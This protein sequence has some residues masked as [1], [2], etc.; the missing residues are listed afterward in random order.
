MAITDNMSV[1]EITGLIQPDRLADNLWELVNVPSATCN[2]RKAGLVFAELLAKSGAEVTI[3]DKIYDSPNII[4]KIKGQRPGKTL[5]LAGHIDH[6]NVEHPSP[7]RNAEIISGRGSADMKNGLAGI[8]EIV[9]IVNELNRD[10]AGNILITVYGLH[11]APDGDSQGLLNLIDKKNKGDAA[12]VFEGPDEYA[13]TMANG[14][15]IFNIELKHQSHSAHEL[16]GD[17]DKTELMNTAIKVVHKL[18][19]K[20]LQLKE[21]EHDFPLLPKESIFT[22]QLHCGDFYNRIPNKANLQGTRRWNPDKTFDEIQKDFA[23][24]LKEV[25]KTEFININNEWIFVGE[26]YQIDENENL[27]GHLRK[28]YHD[29]YQK[30]MPIKG[31]SSVTDTCRLVRNAKIPAVLCGFGTETGHMDYEYVNLKRLHNCCKVALL[32]TLGYL[33]DPANFK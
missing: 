15:A 2:E 25:K 24:M 16:C 8:L 29:I 23:D 1:E 31:H 26:S 21:K 5:Q 18:Q 20:D 10:F 28:A 32:T 22:G 7:E 6:I 13:A 30:P 19:Q 9:N 17:V 33:N 4:A 3:D 27:L 11:E 12:I 14:M